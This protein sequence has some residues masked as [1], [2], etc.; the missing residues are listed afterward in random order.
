MKIIGK[1]S[2]SQYISWLMYIVFVYSILLLIYVIIGFTLGICKIKTAN[3]FLYSF[4]EIWKDYTSP[5][6]YFRFYYPFTNFELAANSIKFQNIFLPLLSL[7]FN[8]LFYYY[9]FKAFQSIS[10]E[11]IFNNKT[12][13]WLNR[14]AILNLVILLISPLFSIFLFE[15][16]PYQLIPIYLKSI[17]QIVF[18]YF[19]IVFLKKGLDLQTENELTI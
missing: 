10:N 3:T 12:V 17:L 6:Y 2:L 11:K 8:V 15:T 9:C 4:Y 16:F 5:R 7:I 18:V 13:K 1:N 19:V 14:F